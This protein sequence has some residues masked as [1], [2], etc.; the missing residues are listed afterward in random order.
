MIPHDRSVVHLVI[1]DFYCIDAALVRAANTTIKKATTTATPLPNSTIS[2]SR[3]AFISSS[4]LSS[5]TLR[6]RLPRSCVGL[7]ENEPDDDMA[8]PNNLFHFYSIHRTREAAAPRAA[9]SLHS[10]SGFAE[11]FVGASSR[12]SAPAKGRV[13]C[14]E[15]IQI[16]E[17]APA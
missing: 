14:S 17:N 12:N 8:L 16:S 7:D 13:H 4:L 9:L 15:T 3:S 5:S 2:L 10:D 11:P 6:I 1:R